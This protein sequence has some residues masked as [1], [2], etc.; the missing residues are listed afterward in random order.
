VRILA[1]VLGGLG[2]VSISTA[3]RILRPFVKHPT[4]E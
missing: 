4:H 3:A 1:A 2:C